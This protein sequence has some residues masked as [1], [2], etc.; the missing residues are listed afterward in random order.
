MKKAYENPEYIKL[1][2]KKLNNSRVNYILIKNIGK[3]LPNNL[4]V[5]KDI[6]ILVWEED[7]EKFHSVMNE[8]AVKINHPYSKLNGWSNL[9]G[10]PDFEFWRMNKGSDLIIDVSYR[11]CCK[12]LMPNYWIPLDNYIQEYLW[13]N[14]IFDRENDWYILDDNTEIVYLIVRSIFDKKV[15]IDS[16]KKEIMYLKNVVDICI[17]EKMLNLIFGKFTKCLLEKIFNDDYD[18]IYRTYI[19]FRDY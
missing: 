11:L 14:K 10:M 13:N 18:T 6:D 3:E 7:K 2:F 5:S 8:I 16:Y 12:S 19:V 4:E 9:Y 17:V 1:L 15:F